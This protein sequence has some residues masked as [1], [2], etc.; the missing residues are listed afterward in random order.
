[1]A[2]LI[3]SVTSY[4]SLFEDSTSELSNALWDLLLLRRGRGRGRKIKY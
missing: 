2:L 3:E 1:M 4:F